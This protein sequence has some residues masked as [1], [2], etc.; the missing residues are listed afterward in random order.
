MK[1]VVI[2]KFVSKFVKYFTGI[3]LLKS[4]T[5]IFFMNGKFHNEKGPAIIYVLDSE[6]QYYFNNIAY[7]YSFKFTNKKWKKKVKQIKREEELQIFK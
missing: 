6:S 2:N 1:V 3:Y 7:G 4:G 5:I